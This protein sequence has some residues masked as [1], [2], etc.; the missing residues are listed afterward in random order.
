MELLISTQNYLV[1]LLE[2]ILSMV[3]GG[4][5]GVERSIAGKTAGMRT[6]SLVAVGATLFIVIAQFLPS[7]IEGDVL[8]FPAA[9]ITGIGF[10]GAG[11][12]VFREHKDSISGLTT[13]A[14]LWVAAGIGV[15]I[16]FGLYLFAVWT[17]LVT[18]FI[19]T[20]MWDIEQKMIKIA[21]EKDVY[22]EE[23]IIRKRR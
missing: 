16:G 8:R 2:I 17:T 18:L 13:A 23:E 4:L 7:G 10:L 19:F 14:G 3:L 9:I 1:P 21:D 20:I 22:T 11:L 5:I 12:I 15:A 6:Y